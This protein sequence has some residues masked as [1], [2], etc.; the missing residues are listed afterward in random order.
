MFLFYAIP[1]SLLPWELVISSGRTQPMTL[2][3]MFSALLSHPLLSP[4][5]FLL[6]TTPLDPSCHHFS[7]LHSGS[8][9]LTFQIYANIKALCYKDNSYH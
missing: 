5:H 4:P 3:L 1:P 8:L 6:T 7:Y 2:G 9:G